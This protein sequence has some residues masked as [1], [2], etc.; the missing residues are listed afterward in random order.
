MCDNIKAST[1]AEF[2]KVIAGIGIKN[3]GIKTAKLL[4]AKFKTIESLMNAKA[5]DIT[6]IDGI[7]E[8]I[9]ESIIDFFKQDDSKNLID[10]LK[11]AGFSLTSKSANTKQSMAGLVFCITGKLAKP[12]AEYEKAI[13]LAGGTLSSSVSSKTSYLITND[14]TSGSSKNKKANELKIPILS[15]EEFVE[16]FLNGKN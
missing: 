7:G 4:A 1:N 15:E 5:E 11:S 6:E 2:Y 3:V 12:R 14:T 13:E 16:K 8:I 9:A 10:E